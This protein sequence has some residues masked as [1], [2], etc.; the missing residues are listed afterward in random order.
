M[1][2]ERRFAAGAAL[3]LALALTTACTPSPEPTPTSTGFASEE[4]A[5]A[6]AEATYRAY[7]DAINLRREEP[8]SLPDPTDFLSGDAYNEELD[9]AR[10]LA[11]RGWHVTGKTNITS[12]KRISASPNSIEMTFCLDASGTRVLDQ[13]GT[14]VTP[15]DRITLLGVDVTF[16]ATGRKVLIANTGTSAEAC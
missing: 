14:D 5:F 3:V 1:I 15:P 2:R 9:T 11:E 13:S 12:V 7:A 8:S 4:E 10:Q 16:A 6:A